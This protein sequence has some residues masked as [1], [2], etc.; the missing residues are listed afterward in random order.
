[1]YYKNFG[2]EAMQIHIVRMVIENEKL[3]FSEEII[4]A[5]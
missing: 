4:T 3:N 1:M 5:N 2:S